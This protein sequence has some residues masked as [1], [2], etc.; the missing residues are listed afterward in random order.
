MLREPLLIP[1]LA[2]TAG[3]L[4]DQWLTFQIRPMTFAAGTFAFL[5]VLSLWKA[6][7]LR[8]L[9]G[10]LMLAAAGIAR[11]GQ[12]ESVSVPVIE[13]GSREIVLVS[14][15]VVD[16]PALHSPGDRTRFLL[17]LEPG[18][19]AQ[20]S[21]YTREGV[22]PPIVHYGERIE[23]EA[24]MRPVRNYRN[25]GAFDFAHY[26]AR[27]SIYWNASASADAR[28]ARKGSCGNALQA[29]I[30]A[31]RGAIE[32]RIETLFPGPD[33][34]A[35]RMMSAILIGQGDGL[36]RSWTEEFRRTGTYH[37]L[38]VSG[39]H[40]TS[41]VFLMALGFRILSAPPLVR[42]LCGLSIG[43]LY[44]ALCGW[45]APVVRAAGA[46][47]LFLI[48]R[49]M[50]RR[51]R[52]LN[53]LAAV[54][55]VYLLW[56]PG[57]LLEASFQLSF[58]AVAAL[59]ALAEPWM[60]H[61][62]GV[63]SNALRKIDK[64]GRDFRL[65]PLGA[66]FR[67]EVRL[68]AETLA[69]WTRIPNAWV[70]RVLAGLWRAAF[71]V[72]E[73]VSVSFVM[74]IA[75][76]I[77]MV[78]YFHRMTWT[79][80]SANL[81]V[82]PLMTLVVPLGLG[83]VA[84]N[85]SILAA[86]ARWCLETSAAIVKWHVS[87]ADMHFERRIPDLPV[88]VLVAASATLLAAAVAFRL[89]PRFRWCG[90]SMACAAMLAMA[91]VAFPPVLDGGILEVTVI[92]VGQG[93]SIL[94]VFP[95]GKRMLVDGGGIVSFGR[96]VSKPRLDTGEDVVAPYLWT[97]RLDRV[98][99]IASTHAHDDHIGGVPA[100]LE[101]FRPAELWTGAIPAEPSESWKKVEQTA[102]RLGVRVRRRM[103]PETLA[104]GGATI[105]ILA[106]AKEYEPSPATARNNDS[107]LFAIRYGS[108]GI[109]LTGDTEKQ[110]E[111]QLV[112]SGSLR[113]IDVLKAGHHGSRT[114]T[115]PE[116]LEA[117]HPRVAIISAGF[118]NQ[119]RHPHPAVLRTL[120]EHGV[121][122]LRTDVHGMVQIR[123]DGRWLEVRTQ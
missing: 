29:S 22:E 85:S 58:A 95:D 59:G 83:A 21:L 5:F 3:I 6:P 99:V 92:D 110:V 54:A 62:S 103:G 9:T 123:T 30:F 87:L 122:V 42:L 38:V 47:T 44:T 1:A 121:Q 52:L 105:E 65:P 102:R 120:E 49:W 51:I 60:E 14:G 15:C 63:Y 37:A 64:K 119:F 117:L 16:P 96:K 11:H 25:P 97:R 86:S 20:V 90:F 36:E 106:P 32:Q 43:W 55:I 70:L 68:L 109:L 18:A 81:A 45:T 107:L 41:I 28:I 80:V 113:P 76:M 50:F 77:P 104:F 33:A 74:Q 101:N 88:W 48:G 13:A 17:E 84:L 12:L 67:V 111:E 69:M 19:I 75:L 4:L 116:F 40:F 31:L 115:T 53:A 26:M 73:L 57:Q 27:R 10:C 79:G 71:A 94:A 46:L 98:D 78:V 8:Y 61:T 35:S 112:A 114:S 118:E 7:R 100:L 91:L 24:R 89:L 34:Y 108:R 56:D 39:M 82:I 66:E 72:W 93:D 23:F 2:L